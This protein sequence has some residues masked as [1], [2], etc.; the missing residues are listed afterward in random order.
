M[1]TCCIR[2]LFRIDGGNYLLLQYLRK[3]VMCFICRFLRPQ[4]TEETVQP[5]RKRLPKQ[6]LQ[7]WWA[8]VPALWLSVSFCLM[9]FF[10]LYCTILCWCIA[11]LYCSAGCMRTYILCVCPL[12][13]AGTSSVWWTV[14]FTSHRRVWRSVWGSVPPHSCWTL[15]WRVIRH[16][17]RFDR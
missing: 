5:Q 15:P 9:A 14:P 10:L 12:F 3:P 1:W 2:K 17:R 7:I 8:V 11:V 4:A 13:T 16:L 6:D